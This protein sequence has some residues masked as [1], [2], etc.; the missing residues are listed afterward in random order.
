MNHLYVT[1]VLILK[2]EF[3]VAIEF[4]DLVAQKV[5]DPNTSTPAVT[6]MVEFLFY[7][8]GSTGDSVLEFITELATSTSIG[9][10]Y[11][12]NDSQGRR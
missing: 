9:F 6:D 12:G 4:H 10:L 8:H 1:N 11:I 7:F 5:T 2:E 3:F